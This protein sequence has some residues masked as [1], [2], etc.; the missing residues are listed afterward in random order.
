MIL[1]ILVVKGETNIEPIF[2]KHF[3]IEACVLSAAVDRDTILHARQ[4]CRQIESY[5]RLVRADDIASV[6]RSYAFFVDV[7]S[8]MT[9]TTRKN[10]RSA[11]H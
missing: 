5:P 9:H 7:P 4:N 10:I 1:A 6:L 2:V 11:I 8:C 3:D